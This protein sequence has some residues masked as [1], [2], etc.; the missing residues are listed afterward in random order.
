MEPTRENLT[1]LYQEKE[2]YR[3]AWLAT[4]DREAALTEKNEQL[5]RQNQQLLETAQGFQQRYE[6]IQNAF[7]WRV[8][9]PLRRLTDA[10]RAS[11]PPPEAPPPAEEPVPVPEEVIE[12]LP[13]HWQEGDTPEAEPLISILIPNREHT[14]DLSACIES[15]FARSSYRN[16]EIII[17]ENGS[18]T[19]TIFRYY[20]NVQRQWENV[21]VIR[22]EGPFN[23]S[24]V[25]NFAAREARGEYLLLLNN[26]TEVLSPHWLEELLF[27]AR[28][29]DVGAVG[30]LLCYGDGSIQHAGMSV[31]AEHP[32]RHIGRGESPDKP[33]FSRPR[34]VDAVTGACLML[35]RSLW[36]A[37]GGMDDTF[38]IA[39]NDVDLCMRAREMGCRSVFTPFARLCHYESKSRQ[40]EDTPEKLRHFLSEMRRFQIRWL[41]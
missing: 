26:D 8:T 3:D 25:N 4:L 29:E 10:L 15:I 36:E 16:F 32:N 19:N 14:E 34:Y 1:A 12:F 22:W 28:Q 13:G 9:K 39:F 24:S 17:A 23:F 18:F 33:E 27:F 31:T 7:W 20:E 40:A 11:P 2:Y 35:R 38:E 21:R 30:A 6:A 5:R 41:T 37:L